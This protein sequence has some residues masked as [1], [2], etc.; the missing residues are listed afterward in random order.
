M[1]IKI[2]EAPNP[3]TFLYFYIIFFLE[4]GCGHAASSLREPNHPAIGVLPK[5]RHLSRLLLGVR[6]PGWSGFWVL[7]GLLRLGVQEGLGAEGSPRFGG[8]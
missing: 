3:C 6:S 1:V 7:G 2:F 8:L 4:G 5:L